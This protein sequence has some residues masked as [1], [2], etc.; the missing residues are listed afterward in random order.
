MSNLIIIG[1]GFDLA[2]GLRTNYLDFKEYLINLYP[3]AESNSKRQF[4]LE[5]CLNCFVDELSAELLFY[6]M[7]K[8]TG[9]EWN[10]FENALGFFD[11]YE[12]FPRRSITPKK[13]NNKMDVTNYLLSIDIISN[14]LI[15]STE[16][17]QDFFKWWIKEVEK[18]FE[19][20]NIMPKTDLKNLF[21]GKRS[22]IWRM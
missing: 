9:L 20:M 8:S 19:T 22:I 11:F 12:K 14:I 17:W 15:Q 5:E 13:N 6:A 10:N 4:D 18:E 2:H 21:Y 3:D 7:N 1:N 16:Y